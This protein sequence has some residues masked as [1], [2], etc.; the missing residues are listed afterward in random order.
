MGG[1]TQEQ[2]AWTGALHGA[3]GARLCSW[4]PGPERG[5]LAAAGLLPLLALAADFL[6]LGSCALTHEFCTPR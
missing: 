5:P 1:S 4:C 3:G 6:W 2:Q